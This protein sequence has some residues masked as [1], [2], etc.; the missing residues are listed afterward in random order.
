MSTYRS[1]T[2]R[3]KKKQR[4]F[5]AK[6]IWYMTDAAMKND[7]LKACFIILN[8]KRKIIKSYE[9]KDRETKELKLNRIY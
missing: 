6:K 7:L 5:H 8:R 1:L 4:I 3:G 9:S 2:S